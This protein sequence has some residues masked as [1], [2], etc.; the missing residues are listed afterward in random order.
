LDSIWRKERRKRG[1]V[2]DKGCKLQAVGYWLLAIGYRL[3]A[4]SCEIR[5]N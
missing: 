1:K 5:E 3:S 4:A 2:Q